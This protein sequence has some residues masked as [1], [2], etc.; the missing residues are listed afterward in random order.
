MSLHRSLHSRN[1]M[2]RHRNVLTRMERI[3]KLEEE[4]RWT[5]EDGVTGLPKVLSIKKVGKKKKK[6]EEETAEAAVEGAAPE[7][8]AAGEDA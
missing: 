1:E 8:G 2:A 4:K 3:E 6:D 7:D 5:E